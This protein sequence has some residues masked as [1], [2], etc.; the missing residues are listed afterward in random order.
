MARLGYL[1]LGIMGLP[2]ARNLRRAGH[3][4][5]AW[6]HTAPKAQKLARDEGAMVCETPK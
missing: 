2:M 1:G 4:V 5:Q 3:E 6:S